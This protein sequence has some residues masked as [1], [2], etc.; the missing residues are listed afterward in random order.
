MGM[1]IKYHVKELM[2]LGV[3][4]SFSKSKYLLFIFLNFN[5]FIH[6]WDFL[7]TENMKLWIF[8]VI[9]IE[10]VWCVVSFMDT[11]IISTPCS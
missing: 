5:K 7:Y 8:S 6:T 10:S 1:R 11:D 9:Y 3:Y 2:G 4:I